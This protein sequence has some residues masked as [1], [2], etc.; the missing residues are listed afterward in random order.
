MKTQIVSTNAI[1]LGPFLALLLTLR[2]G[3]PHSDSV[4]QP[5]AGLPKGAVLAV[6]CVS[7]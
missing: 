1:T 3:T 4:R 2:H 7:R 5:S 6:R